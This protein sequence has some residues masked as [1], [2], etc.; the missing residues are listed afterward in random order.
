MKFNRL[1]TFDMA[2]EYFNHV[3]IIPCNKK[4]A[5]WIPYYQA[6][7]CN[8]ISKVENLYNIT[9]PLKT[10]PYYDKPLQ[11]KFIRSKNILLVKVDNTIHEIKL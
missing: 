7:L 6:Q 3:G 11:V 4:V 5:G 9:F 2:L 1:N 8:L 10:Y